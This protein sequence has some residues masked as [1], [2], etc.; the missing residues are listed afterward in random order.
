M[1][2]VRSQIESA[3][4]RG[5]REVLTNGVWTPLASWLEKAA[6]LDLLDEPVEQPI[7]RARDGEVVIRRERLRAR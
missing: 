3:L 2:T 7:P 4:A 5:V 1:T 6:D